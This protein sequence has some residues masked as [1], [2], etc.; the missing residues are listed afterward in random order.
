M[1]ST[2]LSY[3]II[4][5]RNQK[6]L[7]SLKQYIFPHWDFYFFVFFLIHFLSFKAKK[8]PLPNANREEVEQDGPQRSAVGL[9]T[10]TTA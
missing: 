7:T 2:V 5:N 9:F 3:L 4:K 6:T 10:V 8:E 1:K